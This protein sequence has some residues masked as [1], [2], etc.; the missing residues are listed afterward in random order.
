MEEIKVNVAYRWFLGLSLNDPIPH[1]STISQ[2]RHRRFNET[3]IFQEI[4]DEIVTKHVWE[5]EKEWVRQNRL[6]P[7]RTLQAKERNY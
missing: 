5:E 2:N 6:S 7:K 3:D 1:H 4:F